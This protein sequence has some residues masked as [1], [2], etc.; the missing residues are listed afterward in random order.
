M[1][2]FFGIVS[3]IISAFIIF[4]ICKLQ[5]EDDNI[6]GAAVFGALSI[7]FLIVGI[8]LLDKYCSPRITP[9]DVYR[10]NTNA[11]AWL[12]KHGYSCGSTCLS[13]YVAIQKGEYTLPQKV[14]NFDKE[15]MA[16]IDGV[17]YSLDYRNG[18]VEIW[19]KDETKR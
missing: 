18:E 17:I 7:T 8:S 3:L 16:L 10:G 2:L 9:I 19:L 12:H 6:L 5:K 1:D 11:Q 13:P 15:D 14:H 4:I